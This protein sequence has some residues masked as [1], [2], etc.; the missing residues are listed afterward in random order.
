MNKTQARFIHIKD[1]RYAKRE[2]KSWEQRK[3]DNQ[4]AVMNLFIFQS[5]LKLKTDSVPA[6][7]YKRPCRYKL[8]SE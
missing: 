6:I 3:T 7:F 4:L 8:N 2:R 1:I 5:F